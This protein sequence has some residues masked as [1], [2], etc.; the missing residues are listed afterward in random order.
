M[1]VDVVVI[2]RGEP[3]RKNA[4]QGHSCISR[5]ISDSRMKMAHAPNHAAA[6]HTPFA[7]W[8]GVAANSQNRSPSVEGSV[9]TWSRVGIQT[10][11]AQ[12]TWS[13][14][15]PPGQ[16][17]G[18]DSLCRT[19]ESRGR[20]QPQP[21]RAPCRGRW[22]RAGDESKIG[23]SRIDLTRVNCERIGSKGS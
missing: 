22:V 7:W 1:R 4:T 11:R 15:P 21:H 18:K 19:T 6:R 8:M 16:D 14:G 12:G 20:R 3:K 13:L 5:S 2:V 10:V 17:L 23:S 9:Q